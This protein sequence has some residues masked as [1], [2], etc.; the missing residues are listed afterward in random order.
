MI[1]CNYRQSWYGLEIFTVG[2]GRDSRV[3]DFGQFSVINRPTRPTE[4]SESVCRD[5]SDIRSVCLVDIRTSVRHPDC[6]LNL[7]KL[8]SLEFLVSFTN[9]KYLPYIPPISRLPQTG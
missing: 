9:G 5:I 4:L 7:T 8:L 2:N 6:P 1:G 3:R